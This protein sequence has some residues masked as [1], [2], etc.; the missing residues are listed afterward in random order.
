MVIFEDLHQI[1]DET[2]SLL[3]YLAD[4]IGT[5]RVLLLV[6]YRPEYSHS[7][8]NKTYYTQLRIDPLN[9]ENADE[10]LSSLLGDDESVTRSSD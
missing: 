6:N 9:K 10:M 1:D 5:S 7:W 8:G 2:Q 4:S 3:N